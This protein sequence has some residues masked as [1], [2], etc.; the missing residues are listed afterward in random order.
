MK[1]YK[2]TKGIITGRN[3]TFEIASVEVSEFGLLIRFDGVGKRGKTING[4]LSM[5]ARTFDKIVVDYLNE[6]F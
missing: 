4:G 2:T 1:R 3:G 5:D 6:A